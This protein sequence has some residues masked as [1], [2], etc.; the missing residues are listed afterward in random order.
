VSDEP[1][2]GAGEEPAPAPPPATGL[3]EPPNAGTAALPQPPPDV[4]A[5]PRSR[6]ALVVGV[7]VA[8]VVALIAVVTILGVIGGSK[9][10]Y[11]G[12]G[13]S[14]DYPKGWSQIK[15]LTFESSTGNA[16]SNQAV[17]VTQRD[18]V[19]LAIYRLRVPVTSANLSQI[20]PEVDRVLQQLA[21]Q[22]HGAVTQPASRVTVDGL[23]ALRYGLATT[24]QGGSRVNS[25]LVFVFDGTTEYFFNCQHTADRADEIESGC[26]QVLAS[27]TVT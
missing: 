14:F 21:Q 18:A 2:P 1:T 5:P 4:A 7:I 9:K 26:D 27:F 16:V 24:I 6:R 23:P 15:D 19:I 25:R 10:T 13:F 22:A 20:K 8:A 3:P 17:G 11:S 12:S